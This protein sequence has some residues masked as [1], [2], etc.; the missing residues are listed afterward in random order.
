[1]EW[2]MDAGSGFR[3]WG[4]GV[5]VIGWAGWVPGDGARREA[6]GGS[7]VGGEGGWVVSWSGVWL[8]FVADSIQWVAGIVHS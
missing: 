2:F 1:M 6:G 8:W 4:L 5:P 7:A 3:V